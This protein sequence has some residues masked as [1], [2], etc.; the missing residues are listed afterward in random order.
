MDS[1][2]YLQQFSFLFACLSH[3]H[4]SRLHSLY[5]SPCHEHTVNI[6]IKVCPESTP[7]KKSREQP[8]GKQTEERRRRR[9]REEEE[10]EEEQE[11]EEQEECYGSWVGCREEDGDRHCVGFQTVSVSLSLF[12][13][14]P[15]VT[16]TFL[17]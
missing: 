4:F 10:E 13:S 2:R 12:G 17:Q 7:N 14:S 3:A 8:D 5:S 11:E 16:G 9:R 1:F 15:H 6:S